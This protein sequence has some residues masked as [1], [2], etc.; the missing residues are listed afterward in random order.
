MDDVKLILLPNPGDGSKP[1]KEAGQTLLAKH[2]FLKEM[3]EFNCEYLLVGKEGSEVGEIS[4][5]AKGFVEGFADVFSAELPDE[6]PPLRDIQ[7]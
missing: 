2:K 7:H 5:E 1:S 6:L 3:L 4:E